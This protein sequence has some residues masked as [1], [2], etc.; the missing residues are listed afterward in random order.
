MGRI[1]RNQPCPCGSGRKY[2]RCHGEIQASAPSVSVG[3]SDTELATVFKQHELFEFQRERQQGRGRPII[4]VEMDG[5][6]FVAIGSRVAY[7]SW[8]TFSDFLFHHLKTQFGIEWGKAEMAKSVEEQHPLLRW[9]TI[10]KELADT[11]STVHG[12]IKSTSGFG[13]IRAINRLGYDLYVIEH[14]VQTAEDRRAFER[15]MERLRQPEQF[16][17]ARHEA[18][19]AGILLRAGFDLKWEDEQKRQAG[20]HAEFV[21]TFPQTARS[22]WV[23][24]K[25]RQPRND[26]GAPK[27]THLVSAA[28]QKK[29]SLER[30]VFVELNLPNG[31]IDPTEG[32]WPSY[33]INQIRLLEGQPNAAALPMALIVVS[34][35]SEQG[36][37]EVVPQGLGAI[38]EGF[39]TKHYRQG[40]KVLLSTAIAEREKNP[41]IESL[42][43]SLQEHDEVPTTFDG[44]LPMVDESQRL[45]IGRA[46][47]LP[48]SEIGILEEA[49][50]VEQWS[51]AAGILRMTNGKRSIVYFDLTDAELAAWKRHPETFFGELRP[52]HPP[53]KEPID[54]Y[55]FLL[56]GYTQSPKEKLLEFMAGYNDIEALRMLSQPELVKE[57]ALRMANAILQQGGTPET[58]VWLLRL[59][60][61]AQPPQNT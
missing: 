54:L 29:T 55:E 5:T 35:F 9:F 12:D 6:R 41:E 3:P 14:H 16:F 46:Y 13:A 47:E 49:T 33:A 58:P 2:K 4:S 24:C 39:K 53:V 1:G 20:G 30:L 34:N 44:S 19:V 23:E 10:T 48:D 38:L 56:Q 42:W 40:T 61:P 27:F 57:Y 51:K 28:L 15:M 11:H 32:G 36:Q 43:R 50:V 31:Q 45:L 7:G 59:R 52:H 26:N 37:L 18:R 22:F 21:A 25:M 60:P 17:G 8:K